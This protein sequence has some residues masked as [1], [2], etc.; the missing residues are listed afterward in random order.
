MNPRL[1]KTADM[2]INASRTLRMVLFPVCAFLLVVNHA[3]DWDAR[4]IIII[5]VAM[6]IPVLIT[7]VTLPA[8]IRRRKEQGREKTRAAIRKLSQAPL[9][10]VKGKFAPPRFAQKWIRYAN[11]IP[12]PKQHLQMNNRELPP[13]PR[14]LP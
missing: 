11:A 4:W 13:P 3:V 10:P 7:L 6:F 14:T 9:K 2:I 1:R 8:R 5:Y 12:A